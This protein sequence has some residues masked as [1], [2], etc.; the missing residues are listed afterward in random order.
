MIYCKLY[1]TGRCS[2][3][4]NPCVF[5]KIH[6]E[7]FKTLMKEVELEIRGEGLNELF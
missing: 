2:F 4:C 5:R 6:E 1:D 3:D 7:H